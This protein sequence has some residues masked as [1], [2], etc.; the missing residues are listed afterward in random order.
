MTAHTAE[1][2][3]ARLLVPQLGAASSPS[4]LVNVHRLPSY[5]AVSLTG[6]RF[7]AQGALRASSTAERAS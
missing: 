5:R 7:S 3:R 1:P 6:T 2:G 4:H